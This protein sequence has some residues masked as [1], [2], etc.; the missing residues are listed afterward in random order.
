MPE[1]LLQFEA[2]R[3][4]KP[5]VSKELEAIIMKSLKRKPS[6]RF[7]SAKAMKKALGKLPGQDSDGK[8]D[9]PDDEKKPWWKKLFG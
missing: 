2:V 1:K 3:K 4:L 5:G 7:E 9:S 6:E 8:K